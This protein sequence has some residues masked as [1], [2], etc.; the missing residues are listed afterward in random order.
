[1]L[2]GHPG[3]LSQRFT[4]KLSLA[5]RSKCGIEHGNALLCGYVPGYDRTTQNKQSDHTL[6]NI[7]KVVGSLFP[8]EAARSVALRQLAGYLVLDA[9]ILNTDRLENRCLRNRQSLI[10]YGSL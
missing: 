1:M 6:R 2:D 7:I 4:C 9:L 5:R 10:I 3:S 8:E